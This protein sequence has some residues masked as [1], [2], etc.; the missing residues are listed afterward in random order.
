M[1][2][3]DRKIIGQTEK[4]GEIQV[5]ICCKVSAFTDRYLIFLVALK[6]VH[7]MP[8]AHYNRYR[9]R[10]FS[11]TRC[12]I[13]SI[14]ILPILCS[15]QCFNRDWCFRDRSCLLMLRKTF[16]GL[17]ELWHRVNSELCWTRASNILTDCWSCVRSGLLK[18]VCN[19]T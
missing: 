5:V 10:H 9:Y 13:M 4:A 19:F 15:S 3:F 12:F 16:G 2:H 6:N 1:L 14:R 7:F 18:D 11:N 8:Q 17:Y